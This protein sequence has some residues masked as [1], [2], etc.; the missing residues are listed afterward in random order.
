MGD[1]AVDGRGRDL[2]V[3]IAANGAAIPPAVRCKNA[4]RESDIIDSFLLFESKDNNLKHC[5]T[6]I[7]IA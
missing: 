5:F 2:R 7:V 3:A 6:A 4:R 1:Q